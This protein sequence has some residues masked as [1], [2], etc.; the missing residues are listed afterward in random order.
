R[1]EIVM[2][3]R[4]VALVTAASRGIGA[5]CA[6]ALAARGHAVA[7]LARADDV[8]ALASELGGLGVVGSVTEGRDLEALVRRTLD[9]YGRIDAAVINTGHPPTGSLLELSDADWHAGLDLLLLDVVRLARL[10]TPVMERQGGGAIVNV[11]AFA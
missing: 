3:E 4:P 8:L 9:A 10:V 11:S 1:M 6:R 5:A 2:A 7:L